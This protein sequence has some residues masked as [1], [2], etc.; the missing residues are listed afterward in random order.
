[1]NQAEWR[2]QEGKD[3]DM[4]TGQEAVR[5]R[6][7]TQWA[8]R[9]AAASAAREGRSRKLI[10]PRFADLRREWRELAAEYQALADQLPPAV[11]LCT[12]CGEPLQDICGYCG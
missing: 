4:A 5:A 6:W 12:V 10:G 9:E 11:A 2:A 7:L 1:M 3:K 8:L